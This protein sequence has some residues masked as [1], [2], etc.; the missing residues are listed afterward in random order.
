MAQVDTVTRILDAAE[1][2]FAEHGF[3]ETSLRT[4]TTRADVNLAAVNYHFGSKKALIQA[5]FARFLGPFY[6]LVESSLD[7]HE[8]QHPDTILSIEDILRFVARAMASVTQGDRNRLAIFMRLLGLAY[9]Q[10]QGHLRKYLQTEYRSLFRRVMALITKA[11][12]DLQPVERFWR[13]HFMLGSAAFTLSSMENLR[14]IVEHDFDTK[15]TEEEV[16]GYLLPFLAA[17]IRAK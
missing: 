2:L 3:A 8:K 7:A 15:C 9:N 17:G 4:I 10:G 6:K 12:P 13:F 14:A 5:V 16:V 11:T 1:E